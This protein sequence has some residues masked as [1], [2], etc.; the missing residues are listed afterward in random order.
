MFKDQETSGSTV[1]VMECE[2]EKVRVNSQ[3]GF[4]PMPTIGPD[5]LLYAPV[6]PALGSPESGR[7]RFSGRSPRSSAGSTGA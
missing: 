2:A 3:S 1:I 7:Q 4:D 6:E 5:R